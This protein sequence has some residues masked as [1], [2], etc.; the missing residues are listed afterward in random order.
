MD[1]PKIQT[2]L[3]KQRYQLGDYTAVVLGEIESADAV[4]YHYIL[5]LVRDGEAKP[6]FYVTAEKNPRA[7][8]HMGAHRM[9]VISQAFT[10]E[11]GSSDD[12]R[13]VEAFAAAALAIA[14]K[15]LGLA[16]ETPVRLM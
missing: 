9:R 3:P 2:A 7:R 8:A 1:A 11:I 15:I 14:A 10:D 5:A 6:S 12:W 13:D 4:R 16:D